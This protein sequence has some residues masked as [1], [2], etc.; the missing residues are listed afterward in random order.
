MG[1][2]YKGLTPFV[3]GSL[4]EMGL[5]RVLGLLVGVGYSTTARR[6]CTCCHCKRGRKV[7]L[8]EMAPKVA[9]LHR[10][11]ENSCPQVG[12]QTESLCLPAL[13]TKSR[14]HFVSL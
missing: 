10:D 1:L 14:Y 3:E 5:F 8:S 12:R 4:L 13:D 2:S 7:Y 6:D 9:G 11:T